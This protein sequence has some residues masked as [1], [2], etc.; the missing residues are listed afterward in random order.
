MNNDDNDDKFDQVFGL[1][2]LFTGIW[3]QESC[4]CVTPPLLEKGTRVLNLV[5]NKKY[6]MRARTASKQLRTLSLYVYL[7][8]HSSTHLETKFT[9]CV[10]TSVPLSS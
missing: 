1:L 2:L 4:L 5:R 7:S 10:Y 8:I 3:G 6:D 9:Y